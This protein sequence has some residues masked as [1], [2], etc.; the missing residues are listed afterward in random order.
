MKQPVLCAAAAVGYGALY[1]I[2][3]VR[4]VDGR[5]E[6]S[7]EYPVS[8][9]CCVLDDD[10]NLVSSKLDKVV[11]QFINESHVDLLNEKCVKYF[12]YDKEYVDEHNVKEQDSLAS[13]T[14][15]NSYRVDGRLIV[16]IMWNKTNSHLLGTNFNL[17]NKYYAGILYIFCQTF[18]S[19]NLFYLDLC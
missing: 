10:G 15:N 17:C 1:D 19:P 4:S 6:V 5:E 16:P 7:G 8:A 14:L 11:E 9:N 13:Y 12:N 18:K 3:F 2:S